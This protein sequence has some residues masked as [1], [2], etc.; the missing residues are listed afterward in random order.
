M[1]VD[2]AA[3]NQAAKQAYFQDRL[4]QAQFNSQLDFQHKMMR[5]QA[6]G[7]GLTSIGDWFD[8]VRRENT[9]KEGA[10][11][12]ASTMGTP[13]EEAKDYI[14]KEILRKVLGYCYGGPIKKRRK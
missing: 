3:R 12:F 1:Y 5:D 14:D 4:R 13:N 8:A 10:E 6:I 11:V 2:A 7:Q 9:A